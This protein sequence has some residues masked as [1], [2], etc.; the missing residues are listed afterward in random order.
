MTARAVFSMAFLICSFVF[1]SA[2]RASLRVLTG[3]AGGT[4][5]ISKVLQVLKKCHN[6]YRRKEEM[7]IVFL[8]EYE[9]CYQMRFNIKSNMHNLN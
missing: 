4:T 6:E 2:T 9:K 8:I 3:I 7:C 1:S 5:D